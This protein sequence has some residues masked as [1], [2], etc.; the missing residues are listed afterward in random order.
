MAQLARGRMRN[1][2]PELVKALTG[3]VRSHHRLLLAQQ[4]AHIDFLDQ[5][6]ATISEAIE[7]QIESMSE[8]TSG[9]SDGDADSE[10]A[11]TVED[12]APKQNAPLPPQLAIALLDTIP[13]VDQRVAEIIVAEL[14]T[15]MARLGRCSARQL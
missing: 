4:L 7:R 9:H 13:G 6:I 10:S 5:Q 8:D 15:D 2:I 3:I 1:K 11:E 14:G 12:A